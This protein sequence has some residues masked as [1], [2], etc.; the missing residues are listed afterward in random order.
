MIDAKRMKM[1]ADKVDREKIERDKLD[2]ILK[3]ISVAAKRGEYFMIIENTSLV[4]ESKLRDLGFTVDRPWSC[5]KTTIG[6]Q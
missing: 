4:N 1:I 5:L 6:W 3:G 2:A